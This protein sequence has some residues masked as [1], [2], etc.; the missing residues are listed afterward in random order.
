MPQSNLPPAMRRQVKEANRMAAALQAG[1]DPFAGKGQPAAAPPAPPA[2]G[3]TIQPVPDFAVVGDAIPDGFVPVDLTRGDPR[4]AQPPAAAAP[5]VTA[6]T[7]PSQRW[8]PASQANQQPRQPAPP[9]AAPSGQPAAAPPQGAQPVGE[10]PRYKVL[11][12]KY[13][14]ETRELRGQ[15]SELVAANRALMTALQQRPAAAPPA[16]PPAPKTPRERALAAGFTEKEIDEYGEELVNIIL[17]TAD[18]V[19]GPQIAALRRENAQLASTVQNTNQTVVRSAQDR[20]WDDLAEQVPEW[21]AINASQEWLDW[22]MQ[23]DVFSGRTRNDG[24][25]DAF[26]KFDARRA[27]AIFEAFKAEDAR[28]RP[29]APGTHVDPATLV[30]PGQPAAST[31]APAGSDADT[32]IWTEEE[33]R[34][35]YSAVRR[36]HI[37]GPQKAQVEAEINRALVTGRIRPEHNDA[38]LINSR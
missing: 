24:L 26:A 36:G 13:D 20:F 1:Q 28:A 29:T 35:F 31:P 18:N 15:V 8:T 33:V 2:P 5:A 14:A 17:R 23:P 9:A 16:P 6:P 12:G 4:A 27:V 10:D 25:Q 7:N 32:K 3:A 37:K 21:A 11:R 30:A 22:L 19:A 34:Q 38:Y